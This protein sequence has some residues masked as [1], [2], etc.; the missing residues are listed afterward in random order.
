MNDFAAN[1]VTVVGS[2]PTGLA[3]ALSL[4]NSGIDVLLLEAGGLQTNRAKPSKNDA[5]LADSSRHA[6]MPMAARR[7]FGGTSALW[8]GR[9]V[10]FDPI[11]LEKRDWVDHSG[12][13]ISWAELAQWYPAACEFLD[14]GPAWFDAG[15]ES[16]DI[17]LERWSAQPNIGAVHAR[18]IFSHPRIRVEANAIVTRIVL[19]DDARHAVALDLFREGQ[20][21]RVPVRAVVVAAGGVETARLLLNSR[22]ERPALFGG[23]NGPLGRYYMGHIYGSIADIV[24]TEPRADAAFDYFQD[25][26]GHYA[27]KRWAIPS[28]E[29]TSHRYLNMAA[30]PE[31]P[32]IADARH[33]SAVLSLGYLALSAPILG[34]RLA[35]PGIRAR[36][37]EGG[38][39][40]TWPHIANVLRDPFAAAAFMGRFAF[41]RYA[42]RVRK[43]GFFPLNSARRYSLFHHGEHAPNPTSRVSLSAKRDAAGMLEARI[44][45]RFTQQ[46]ADSI[47]R[48]V[49]EIGEHLQVQGRAL[50]DYLAPEGER[51]ALALS[52][53]ADGYHQI[54]TARM[55]ADPR[56][57]VVDSGARVHGVGNL[58]LAGSSIFPTSGQA[59]PTLTAVALA[60]RLAEHLKGAFPALRPLSSF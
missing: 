17:K 54:G 16:L 40:R 20:T 56:L 58:F 33:R 13:P 12:W 24:F 1:A 4:A 59:N 2:G 3:I 8:G 53:A 51:A 52:Q 28:S 36:K 60:L 25:A 37:L 6:P 29:Q 41:A 31:A 55:A 38:D 42:S 19:D 23:E 32:A 21:S 5:D 43:P 39:R 14:C 7:G 11:D 48:G 22:V 9:A 30:W 15:R 26:T 47:A 45:L 35:S 34:P 44:D 10:P 49:A 46:D 18:A 57:G 27:R 50:L